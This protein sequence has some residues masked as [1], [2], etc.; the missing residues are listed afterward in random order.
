MAKDEL[1]A[2]LADELAEVWDRHEHEAELKAKIKDL[3]AFCAKHEIPF[4]LV[5]QANN[6]ILESGRNSSR[7]N[8]SCALPGSRI[9]V[10]RRLQLASRLISSDICRHPLLEGLLHQILEA[11]E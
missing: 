6:Q 4:V 8:L 11:S 3:H 7:I 10:D 1:T 9:K 5:Y 2:R